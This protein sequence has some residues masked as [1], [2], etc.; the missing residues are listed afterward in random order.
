MQTKNVIRKE[1]YVPT[2]YVT[3]E[4]GTVEWDG[5]SIFLIEKDGEILVLSRDDVDP[6][7]FLLLETVP[8]D[9]QKKPRLHIRHS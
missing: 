4:E 2:E 3:F 8:L 6:Y 9:R 1:V 7:S 5:D